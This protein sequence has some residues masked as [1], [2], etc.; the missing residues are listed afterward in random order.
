MELIVVLVLALHWLYDFVDQPENIAR[1][2]STSVS[3]L[4]AHVTNYTLGVTFVLLL[5]IFTSK[6]FNSFYD[7]Y[8]VFC[9][10]IITF[11]MHFITDFITSKQSSRC[12][13]NQRFYGWNSFW[14][15]IGLDQL[16]H[17]LQLLYTIKLLGLNLY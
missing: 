7:L 9:F 13:A 12:Y 10:G 14:F 11:L 8:L 2:K 1:N 6:S 15:W 5:Y 3:A 17:T 4:T 16:L